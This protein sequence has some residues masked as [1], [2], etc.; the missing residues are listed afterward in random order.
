M[1]TRGLCSAGLLL[2]LRT[3]LLLG[4]LRLLLVLCGLSCLSLLL[5]LFPLLVF[6]GV[7]GNSCSEARGEL[8]YLEL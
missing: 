5:R 6:L 7:G 1:R 8:L 4:W 2:L 3:L